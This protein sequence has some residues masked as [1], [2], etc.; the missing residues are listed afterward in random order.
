[1]LR[2]RQWI[3]NAEVMYGQR[4]QNRMTI[5]DHQLYLMNMCNI[6]E[7]FKDRFNL[8]SANGTNSTQITDN[9]KSSGMVSDGRLT[10]R[11][12]T[13]VKIRQR[14]KDNR[15]RL[16]NNTSKVRLLWSLS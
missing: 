12:E 11:Q 2:Q 13:N 10:G 6:T 7:Y 16:D 8:Y 5:K 14:I 3:T 9:T 15:Q 1:M 4:I